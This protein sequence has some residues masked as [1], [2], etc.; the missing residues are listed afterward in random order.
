MGSLATL[1]LDPDNMSARSRTYTPPPQA[2]LQPGWEITNDTNGGLSY[3]TNV[4]L[5]KTRWDPPFMNPQPPPPLPLPPAAAV[6]TAADPPTVDTTV[7]T[8][9]STFQQ[10]PPPKKS[11]TVNNTFISSNSGGGVHYV[12]LFLLT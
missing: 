3:Y 10:S 12:S 1:L 7:A 8:P 6:A 5:G 2:V 4:T 11:K 9:S